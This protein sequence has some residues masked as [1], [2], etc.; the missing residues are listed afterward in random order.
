MLWNTQSPSRL[1]RRP[2]IWIMFRCHIFSSWLW[3]NTLAGPSMTCKA[4]GNAVASVPVVASFSVW[5]YRKALNAE[6]ILTDHEAKA[7][8]AK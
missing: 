1:S 2:L 6:R 8:A 4:A 7:H 3:A 5:F